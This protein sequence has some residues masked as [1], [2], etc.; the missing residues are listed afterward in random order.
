[1]LALP[2]FHKKK[3]RYHETQN[4]AVSGNTDTSDGVHTLNLSSAIVVCLTVS[5]V[6]IIQIAS[7][8]HEG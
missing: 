1:M 5:M 7:S 3:N 4:D 6:F 2:F 8:L